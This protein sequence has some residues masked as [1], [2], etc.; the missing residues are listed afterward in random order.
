MKQENLENKFIH[1]PNVCYVCLLCF[2]TFDM[3]LVTKKKKPTKEA[4]LKAGGLNI[5]FNGHSVYFT[6]LLWDNGCAWIFFFFPI[7]SETQRRGGRV[8]DMLV[9]CGLRCWCTSEA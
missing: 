2:N 5:T 9:C 1:I 8:A 4:P 3:N 7:V 6:M